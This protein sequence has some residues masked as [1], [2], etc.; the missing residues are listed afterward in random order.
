MDAVEITYDLMQ[1]K[2]SGVKGDN[3]H[4]NNVAVKVKEEADCVHYTLYFE[5]TL[6]DEPEITKSFRVGKMD[7]SILTAEKM[8]D[9][10]LVLLNTLHA[11]LGE[12]PVLIGLGPGRSAS[13]SLAT[14]FAMQKQVISH[15]ESNPRLNWDSNIFEFIG[16]WSALFATMAHHLPIMAD[17]ASWYLPHVPLI[18]FVCPYTKFVCI[19]RDIDEVVESFMLK[20]PKTS[21]WT[22]RFSKHWRKEWV[23]NHFNTGFPKYDLPKREACKKYVEEY[24]EMAAIYEKAYPTD[25]K[26]FDIDM[27]NSIEGRKEI[28]SHCLIPEDKMQGLSDQTEIRMNLTT[29]M[30]KELVEERKRKYGKDT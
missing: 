4:N 8:K 12:K 15:H 5:T 30:H 19:Y 11:F 7:G 3:S 23:V 13:M 18:K 10:S 26:I 25:F 20:N 27:L 28:L 14:F 29:D 21:Q 24:Y 6:G 9:M 2:R 16:K 22:H 1:S 17:T